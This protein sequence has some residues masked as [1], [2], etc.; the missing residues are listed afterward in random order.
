MSE[1]ERKEAIRIEI[2]L[3]EKEM[4]YFRGKKRLNAR[5]KY[6]MMCSL[7]RLFV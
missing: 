5:T 1:K 3:M 4:V 2:E 7:S 6:C